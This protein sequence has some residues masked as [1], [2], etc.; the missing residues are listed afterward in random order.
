MPSPAPTTQAPKHMQAIWASQ[1]DWMNGRDTTT[2]ST[3]LDSDDEVQALG[4]VLCG[5]EMSSESERVGSAYELGALAAAG[6][7]SA[8]SALV[9]GA[10]G[11]E[12]SR[13]AAMYGLASAGDAAVP[14]L[15]QLLQHEAD[16]VVNHAAH[17][18]GEASRTPTLEVIDALEAALHRGASHV[19]PESGICS[20]RKFRPRMHGAW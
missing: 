13:R 10:V 14:S 19:T 6:S 3:T 18:L 9:M 20:R 16:N 7:D 15:L 12:C 17:A 11:E 4:R 8:L 1:W 2:R 5:D